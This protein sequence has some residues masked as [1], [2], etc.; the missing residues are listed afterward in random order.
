MRGIFLKPSDPGWVKLTFRI[1][2]SFLSLASSGVVSID[3]LDSFDVLKS[4]LSFGFSDC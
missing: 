2:Y 4:L 1:L 3:R